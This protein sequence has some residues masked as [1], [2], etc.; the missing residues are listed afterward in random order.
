[1]GNQGNNIS[2]FDDDSTCTGVK[3][4]CPNGQ[5]AKCVKGEWVCQGV[6]LEEED[7][8]EP[9]NASTNDPDRK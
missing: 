7:N 5:T 2:N 9:E 1:M 4:L 6:A 8:V 3:P